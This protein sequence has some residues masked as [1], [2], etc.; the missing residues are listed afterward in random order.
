[1]KGG[2]ASWQYVKK[3]AIGL[4]DRHFQYLGL[5]SDTSDLNVTKSKIKQSIDRLGVLVKSSSHSDGVGEGLVPELM[6]M[7]MN[8]VSDLSIDLTV[9][10]C[11]T[12]KKGASIPGHGAS[13]FVP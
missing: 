3:K 8:S 11:K 1:M 13:V 7:N 12:K 2:L 9:L 10:C 6:Q 4:A 5:G